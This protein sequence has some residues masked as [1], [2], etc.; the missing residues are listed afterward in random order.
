L[1]GQKIILGTYTSVMDN[2]WEW[3]LILVYPNPPSQ[4]RFEDE[5]IAQYGFYDYNAIDYPQTE[6]DGGG[7]DYYFTD[8]MR[9]IGEG[10]REQDEAEAAA[11]YQSY[12]LGPA[13]ESPSVVGAKPIL[14]S[15]DPV[16]TIATDREGNTFYSVRVDNE[17][18]NGLSPNG[19]LPTLF[20][21]QE[22]FYPIGVV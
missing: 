3:P 13:E 21:E 19:D 20:P 12:H 14:T 6:I 1:N 18:F 15:T 5:D 17:V 10:F 22:I 9:M 11:R 16:G 2:A 7:K 8:W 4:G